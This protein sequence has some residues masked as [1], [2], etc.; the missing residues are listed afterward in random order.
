MLGLFPCALSGHYEYEM[1]YRLKRCYH[2]GDHILVSVSDNGHATQCPHDPAY[3]RMEQAVFGHP[4][5]ID[6]EGG[7]EQQH[8]GKVPVGG[9]RCCYEYITITVGA[10]TDQLPAGKL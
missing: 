2:R 5:D 4:R 3:R 8:Q 10:D 7:G 9:M 1:G 6:L